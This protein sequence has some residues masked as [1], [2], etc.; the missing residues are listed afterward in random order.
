MNVTR[1]RI[2]PVLISLVLLPACHHASSAPAPAFD[3]LSGQQM[4]EGNFHNVYEAVAALR[5]NWLIV[6]G[7]DSFQSPSQ[8]WVYHD[9]TKLGGVETLKTVLVQDIAY[10]RHYNGTDATTRWGVG[11]AAGVIFVSS[12]P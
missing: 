7:T 11:H 8:V 2:L 10:V 3:Y 12:H 5:G 6:H 1:R 9:Q 4:L